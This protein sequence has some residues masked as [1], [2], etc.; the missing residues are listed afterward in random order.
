MR[1]LFDTACNKTFVLSDLIDRL[2]FQ[3]TAPKSMKV[4][5]FSSKEVAI[6]SSIVKLH[7]RRLDGNEVFPVVAQTS[8]TICAPQSSTI[9]SQYDHLRDLQLADPYDPRDNQTPV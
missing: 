4:T 1:L 7:L 5:T 8:P 9:V 3:T 6:E 2:G